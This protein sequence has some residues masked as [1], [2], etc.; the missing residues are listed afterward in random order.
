M[1]TSINHPSINWAGSELVMRNKEPFALN[2]EPVKLPK[3][4]YP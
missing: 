3:D 4:E 1:N 2:S